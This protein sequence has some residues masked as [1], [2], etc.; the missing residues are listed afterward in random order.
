VKN[1]NSKTVQR[2]IQWDINVGGG[3]F[4]RNEL[5]S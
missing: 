5:K 2:S 1:E 4:L 3:D